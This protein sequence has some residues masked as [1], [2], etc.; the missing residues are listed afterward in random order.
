M[1][2]NLGLTLSPHFLEGELIHWLGKAKNMW[3]SIGQLPIKAGW[4]DA[5]L[6]LRDFSRSNKQVVH[7]SWF[8]PLFRLSHEGGDRN[9]IT[10]PT[11]SCSVFPLSHFG[12]YLLQSLIFIHFLI[13]F[14]NN[15]NHWPVCR[16]PRPLSQNPRQKF[17][18]VNREVCFLY[19]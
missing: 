11:L 19:Q 15:S 18:P 14:D 16:F 7:W 12:I 17:V 10:S 13:V 6:P 1:R 9:W 5:P 2:W 3:L 8:C 4:W